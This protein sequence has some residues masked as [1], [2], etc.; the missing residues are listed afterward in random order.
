M[1]RAQSGALQR[2]RRRHSTMAWPASFA[3]VRPPP[4]Q[5]LSKVA[6]G[7]LIIVWFKYG[8]FP[9]TL[10]AFSIAVFPII[11]TTARG[12]REV[13]PELFDALRVHGL[14][15][16]PYFPLAGGFLTGKYRSAADFGASASA[17]P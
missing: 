6:L 14:S 12:L 15:L 7:P 9:N 11:L 5:C 8:M 3:A 13:E 2:H 4:P 17:R 16:V 10:I 1:G